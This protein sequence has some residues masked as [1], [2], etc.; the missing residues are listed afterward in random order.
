M[1]A[2]HMALTG[3]LLLFYLM[4]G[5]RKRLHL[6]TMRLVCVATGHEVARFDAHRAHRH[7][8]ERA[9]RR[10]SPVLARASSPRSRTPAP[11]C[12]R[13]AAVMPDAV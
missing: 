13:R 10:A 8:P 2:C 4:L 11:E 3:W 5:L 7:A 6:L 9:Q 12:T 1:L